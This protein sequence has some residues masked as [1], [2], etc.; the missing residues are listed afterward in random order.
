MSTHGQ[1]DRAKSMGFIPP[2]GGVENMSPGVRF[3]AQ[4]GFENV[5]STTWNSDYKFVYTDTPQAATAGYPHAVMADHSAFTL[6]E[7]GI[8]GSVLPGQSV[9]IPLSLTTPTA[10]G[11]HA[12]TWQLQTPDGRPFGPVRWMRATVVAKAVQAPPVPQEPITPQVPLALQAEVDDRRA[13]VW[14]VRKGLV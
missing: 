13:A 8:A 11:T 1:V 3:R 7:L 6:A 5:G 12:T 10:A 9:S 4:W 2:E 14:A